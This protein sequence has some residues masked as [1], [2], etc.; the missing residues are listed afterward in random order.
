MS[1]IPERWGERTILRIEDDPIKK[2]GMELILR[3]KD[4]PRPVESDEI[5]AFLEKVIK[6]LSGEK[7]NLIGIRQV[8][9]SSSSVK[10]TQKAWTRSFHRELQ[11]YVSDLSESLTRRGREKLA[12]VLNDLAESIQS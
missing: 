8:K 2:S 10:K 1:H 3:L 4:D 12:K 11:Q 5:K 7:T 6:E 9:H